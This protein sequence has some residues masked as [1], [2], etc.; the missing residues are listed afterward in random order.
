MVPAKQEMSAWSQERCLYQMC[1]MEE[2]DGGEDWETTHLPCSQMVYFSWVK[3][4]ID[5]TF[6][7]LAIHRSHGLCRPNCRDGCGGLWH[8]WS[9]LF[10]T[11]SLDG[12]S[13]LEPNSTQPHLLSP[14]NS[15]VLLHLQSQIQVWVRFFLQLYGIAASPSIYVRK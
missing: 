12:F 5:P 4:C 9:L 3:M 8:E 10:I 14:N 7:H 13:H 2:S 15:W 6:I 1:T 11:W